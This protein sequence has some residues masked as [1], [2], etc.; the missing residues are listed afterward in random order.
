MQGRKH[1]RTLLWHVIIEVHLNLSVHRTV[2]SNVYSHVLVIS[3]LGGM[4]RVYRP[5][6]NIPTRR[7]ITNL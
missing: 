6:R 5:N 3:R 4:L 7:D 2:S 1:C